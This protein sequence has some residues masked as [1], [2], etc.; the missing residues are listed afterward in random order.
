VVGTPV[1]HVSGMRDTTVEQ[2]V[3]V[4]VVNIVV[5]DIFERIIVVI[6]REKVYYICR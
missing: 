4:T 3:R 1:W 5:I 6:P 2:A